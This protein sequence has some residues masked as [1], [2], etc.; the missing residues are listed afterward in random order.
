SGD[1]PGIVASYVEEK[2]GA[3][4]LYINGAAGNI[5]PI[6]TTQPDVRSAHLGEFRVLLGDKILQ[7]NRDLA[8]GN[9]ARLWLA[10]KWV[11][12][13]RR[14]GLGWPSDLPSYSTRSSGG[15]DLV[16]I[17]VRFL[18][19]NDTVL[20]ASPVE[21]FCEIAIH[22]RN[23]SPFR[24]TLFLGYTN[25]WLGYL[26][27]AEAFRQGGYEPRTSPFTGRVEKDFRDAVLSF[28]EDIPRK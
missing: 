22:V 26:P 14:D 1:G 5:A 19:V 24:H 13:P 8:P 17:P 11:E 2:L 23:E 6:Y 28:L 4:M 25:G 10:E 18:R 12:T 15:T 9:D 3:P 27:T 21:L 16:R 20:W 7:A